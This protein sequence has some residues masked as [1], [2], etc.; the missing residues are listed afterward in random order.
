MSRFRKL[1]RWLLAWYRI[2]LQ[3]VCEESR[4]KGLCDYHD[5][6]DWE[7]GEPWHFYVGPCKRCGKDFS[8]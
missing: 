7:H 1:W 8:I 5:Y 6:P 3:V 2:D 4:G